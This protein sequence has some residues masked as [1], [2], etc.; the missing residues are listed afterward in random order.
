MPDL[1][2]KK[3]VAQGEAHLRRGIDVGIKLSQMTRKTIWGNW[4]RWVQQIADA[5]DSSV[6]RH[7]CV[8][9]C[10][11]CLC[12]SVLSPTCQSRAGLGSSYDSS[13]TSSHAD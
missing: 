5:L 13:S 8:L 11:P 12:C 10:S 4:L 9:S 2:C 6:I 1:F 7:P 3:M